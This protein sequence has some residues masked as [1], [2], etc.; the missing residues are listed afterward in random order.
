[1]VEIES[2]L[3][4]STSRLHLCLGQTSEGNSHKKKRSVIFVS[5]AILGNCSL[6]FLYNDERLASRV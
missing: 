5:L 6:V 2:E 4:R 1:M 3:Q